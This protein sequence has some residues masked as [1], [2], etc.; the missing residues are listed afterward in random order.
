MEEKLI[1]DVSKHNGTIN[2]E[3]VKASGING[4]IIRCGYGLDQTN[5]DDERFIENV[6]GAAA[7][8][9]PIG[10]YLYSYAKTVEEVDNEAAHALRLANGLNLAMPIF[11]DVEEAGT[12]E[13]A[14]ERAN[15]FIDIMQ[16]NGKPVGIY[17]NEYWYNTHLKNI[18]PVAWRW[19]AK[20]GTNTGEPQN[21]PNVDD[22][23]IWQY[24]SRGNVNGINGN[25]DMSICYRDFIGGAAEPKKSNDEIVNEVI[26]GNWGNGEERKQALI[27]AG[28]DYDAI[29]NL[30]NERM[31]SGAAVATY[32]IQ[33]GDTLTSIARE[34][35]T[36]I[37]KL[38]K[39]NNIENANKIYAGQTIKIN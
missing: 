7:A 20:Y 36:T 8:G 9:V 39:L 30:V 27:N 29:Q 33:P 28:Y 10:I 17:A 14:E 34:F 1:I 15:R 31:N 5:Q 23:S 21:K 13:A 37:N 24:T 19:V 16:S 12:E 25:V 26:A 38:K 11:Y 18:N 22:I 3:Q 6:N 2:W 4:A 32:E 35:N